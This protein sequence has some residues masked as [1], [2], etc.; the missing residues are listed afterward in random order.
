MD[1]SQTPIPGQADKCLVITY[2]E[3]I[4]YAGLASQSG[5][6]R[7]FVGSLFDKSGQEVEDSRV[8]LTIHSEEKSAYVCFL[9]DLLCLA[10]V[11]T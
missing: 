8:S 4:Q 5:S 9:G 2:A 1:C 10:T 11:H 6:K 7:I 3:A